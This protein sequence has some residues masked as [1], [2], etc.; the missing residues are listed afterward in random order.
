MYVEIIKHTFN[1]SL[2]VQSEVKTREISFLS[3]SCYKVTSSWIAKNM[4]YRLHMLVIHATC[5]LQ[6]SHLLLWNSST[7]KGC[8]IK[9]QACTSYS[10]I[11]TNGF[12]LIFLNQICSL[13]SKKFNFTYR[14]Y[15][16]IVIIKKKPQT[17]HFNTF[18]TTSNQFIKQC[19]YVQLKMYCETM[20]SRKK[21]KI[22][23]T[24]KRT[25]IVPFYSSSITCWN[26]GK[27]QRFNFQKS[28]KGSKTTFSSC[29]ATYFAI[30][31]KRNMYLHSQ[32]MFSW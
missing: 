17:K 6:K 8:K 26:T 1:S 15:L 12:K 3:T 28:S 21:W 27:V 22:V 16:R 4:V 14:N 11:K 10:W 29:T 5:G 18:K 25:C 9:M 19:H 7:T 13:R 31:W 32:P 2:I 24:S 20:L 23:Y 30:A